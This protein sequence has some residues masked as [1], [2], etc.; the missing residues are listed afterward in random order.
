[1]RA[2]LAAAWLLTLGPGCISAGSPPQTLTTITTT[3]SGAR[4]FING[5]EVCSATPCNWN[6][7][8]GL[9]H[10][11]HLQIRRAGYDEIDLYLD[12]ELTFF[13]GPFSVLAFKMPRQLSFSLQG[14]GMTPVAPAPPSSDAPAST[15]PSTPPPPPPSL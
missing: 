7:G 4:V 5:A 11:Y 3:P 14:S 1:M 10:R 13:S 6:E 12:K 15:T 2:A 9:A 8:D